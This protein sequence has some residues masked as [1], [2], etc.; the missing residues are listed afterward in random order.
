V[1]LHRWESG[2]GNT[3]VLCL[4]ETAVT[5]DVWRPLAG[6][7]GDRARTIAYDRRGWGRSEAPEP[8]L[9]T[10]VPEQSEDA[11]VLVA[12]LQAAP[13]LLCGAGLGAVAALDLALRHP[14]LVRG[15]V[16]IEPP[17]FAFVPEAT[18]A[19]SADG[20]AIREAFQSGGADAALDLYLS[21]ALPGLG[22]GVER[23]PDEATAPAR[24]RPLTLF[25]ELGAV[26]AWDLPLSRL[27]ASVP[28]EVVI[29]SST[30]TL[31]RSA[32]DAL[33]SRLGLPACRELDARGL[34]QYDAAPQLAEL[35]LTL[36]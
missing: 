8:Y 27:P 29:G 23:L 16:L 2:A 20:L 13:A 1:E 7:V 18:E 15:A 17:L 10:T 28:V 35:V 12:E 26:P 30:P 32:C 31:V 33:A 6:A 22:P 3:A 21:G 25:A 24:S 34:P 9:R 4:H 5:G 36:A 19:L 14:D 11:A